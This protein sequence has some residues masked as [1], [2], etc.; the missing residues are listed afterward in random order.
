[1]KSVT[2]ILRIRRLSLMNKLTF[3]EKYLFLF[4][5]NGLF[6][7]ATC[8]YSLLLTAGFTP[9]WHKDGVLPVVNLFFQ[10]IYNENLCDRKFF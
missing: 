3:Q 1:M 10:N 7:F 4:S 8:D 5:I 2:K 9:R 6:V